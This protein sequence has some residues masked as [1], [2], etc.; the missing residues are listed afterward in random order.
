M[1]GTNLVTQYL[2]EFQ[3]AGRTLLEC[4]CNNSHSGN[5][6][7]RCANENAASST[8]PAPDTVLITRTGAMLAALGANDVIVTSM[9]PTPDER[10]AASTEL[11][12][13]LAIYEQTSY[14]SIAHG[15]APW[16]VLAGWM[17]D[18]LR[19]IDVEGAYYF[20]R[21]PV[22]ECVPATAS[23]KT[24][25]ALAKAL[26]DVPVVILRGHGM[27]AVGSRI[28][29]AMQR[30]TSVNDSARLFV[31]ARRS[32]LDTTVLAQKEYLDFGRSPSLSNAPPERQTGDQ[33]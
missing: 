6:S 15:H 28:T 23:A 32:G 7:V 12:V 30:I 20:G 21:V 17:C 2:P 5:L 10:V 16:A 22:V 27:F 13:H 3:L 26:A 11:P 25:A 33:R 18:E 24:G 1:S 29:E 14:G 8:N 31:E 19:P 9:M 4:R